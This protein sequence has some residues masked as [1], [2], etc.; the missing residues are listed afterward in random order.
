MLSLPR[1]AVYRCAIELLSF[2]ATIE[3]PRGLSHL[4]DPLRRAAL[5]VP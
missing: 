1:L 2:T 3:F 4:A 5:S